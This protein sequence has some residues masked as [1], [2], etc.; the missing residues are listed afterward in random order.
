VH[1]CDLGNAISEQ[2]ASPCTVTKG[3]EAPDASKGGWIA[4]GVAINEGALRDII[5]D[6]VGRIGRLGSCK[7]G[8]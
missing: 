4:I 3:A 6:W 8:R 5:F 7:R 2:V 1:A